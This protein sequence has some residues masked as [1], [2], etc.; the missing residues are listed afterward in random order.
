MPMQ[1]WWRVYSFAR[2]LGV[3]FALLVLGFM[4]VWAQPVRQPQGLS[5]Q[6]EAALAYQEIFAE[7]SNL[8]NSDSKY[9]P[10]A[11]FALRGRYLL[12]DNVGIFAVAGYQEGALLEA[13]AFFPFTPNPSDP[14]GWH[15]SL[16]VGLSY[17]LKDSS[18]FG[19]VLNAQVHYNVNDN[20]FLGLRYDHRPIITPR[21]VQALRIS[22]L[23]GWYFP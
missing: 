8:D 6:L 19:L 5:V 16:G 4:W 2:L 18:A 21:W 7:P 9:Q 15:T 1:T 10:T 14:F 20:F 3:A 13:G 12:H 22:L 17:Q 23:T 11:A